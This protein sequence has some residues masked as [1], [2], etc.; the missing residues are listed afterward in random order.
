MLVMYHSVYLT[1]FFGCWFHK[2]V[3]RKK[4]HRNAG[5]YSTGTGG[6]WSPCGQPPHMHLREQ[7]RAPGCPCRAGWR[8]RLPV[9]LVVSAGQ[10]WPRWA[11][12]EKRQPV[13][14]GRLRLPCLDTQ[15][16]RAAIFPRASPICSTV[17]WSNALWEHPTEE[18]A[19]EVG[20]CILTMALMAQEVR[21]GKSV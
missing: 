16:L 1:D 21:V 15:S 2:E 14:L 11:G 19:P 13:L 6:P 4:S 10:R 7:G 5:P 18:A 17:T 12:P 8:A 3:S 9:F 20:S